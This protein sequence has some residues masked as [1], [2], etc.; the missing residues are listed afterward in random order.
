MVGRVF[1]RCV[2]DGKCATGKCEHSFYLAYEWQGRKWRK[3]IRTLYGVD[4]T[5]Q[6]EA[7]KVWL[8]KFIAEITD[9]LN[10]KREPFAKSAPVK[11]LT[12]GDF[13]RD[14]YVPGYYE[15][16]L[17][18]TG[19]LKKDH[20]TAFYD[21]Q[22]LVTKFGTLPLAALE[23]ANLVRGYKAE[24][25]SA[26]LE[27]ASYNK[28][29]AKLRQILRWGHAQKERYISFVPFGVGGVKL[30]T[31]DENERERRLLTDPDEEEM[32]LDAARAMN[33]S[34]H[35]FVGE[36]MELRIIAAIDT[37]ARRGELLRVTNGQIDYKREVIKLPKFA[38]DHKGDKVQGTKTGERRE[39][40]I[41]PRLAELLEKRRFLG[42]DAFVF[43]KAD[44]TPLAPNSLRKPF[45]TLKLIA[46]GRKAGYQRKDGTTNGRW[47][48]ES[49]REAL[50]QVNLDWHDLRHEGASRYG[51]SGK[52]TLRELMELLGHRRP[53]TTMR[54]WQLGQSGLRDSVHAAAAVIQQQRDARVAA[55]KLKAE[56]S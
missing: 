31:K 2:E 52:L 21:V 13:V 46:Y 41:T 29:L 19:T 33:T 1:K 32:L 5:S 42:A 50:E 8:P 48:D 40:P 3:S 39:V 10:E 56:V 47:F 37:C 26:G 7:E 12:F 51:E 43:G 24:L 36:M 54:Y 18:T 23:D 17:D 45:S 4:V 27:A 30:D 35:G 55:R 28:R 20:P 34:A 38:T 44:G 25:Q 16:T 6:R 9:A 15:T 11:A 53:E 22:Q 14:I 49:T